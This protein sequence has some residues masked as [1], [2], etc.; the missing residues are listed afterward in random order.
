VVD[1]EEIAQNWPCFIGYS[2]EA[3]NERRATVLTP[4]KHGYHYSYRL[5]DGADGAAKE[6]PSAGALLMAQ[7]SGELYEFL[8]P[9]LKTAGAEA[10]E[11][12]KIKDDLPKEEIETKLI[13]DDRYMTTRVMNGTKT[14]FVEFF[15]FIMMEVWGRNLRSRASEIMS[16]GA[17]GEL[18][19]NHRL[20]PAKEIIDSKDFTPDEALLARALRK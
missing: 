11:R 14:L 13:N 12:L 7:L 9:G 6:S 17:S 8:V 20:E 15:G 5:R 16:R 19:R 3:I 18:Y 1:N 2:K 4:E 10:I